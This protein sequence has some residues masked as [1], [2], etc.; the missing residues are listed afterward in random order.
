MLP[1]QSMVYWKANRPGDLE[2]WVAEPF[3]SR[4]GSA[5]KALDLDLRVSVQMCL[6]PSLHKVSDDCQ[7]HGCILNTEPF[8]PVLSRPW[9]GWLLIYPFFVLF[10]NML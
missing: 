5:A 7:C 1:A 6:L 4:L 9:K 8:I 3:H 2:A 10:S